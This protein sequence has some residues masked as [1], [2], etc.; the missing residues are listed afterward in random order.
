[1]LHTPRI[2]VA[3]I[4]AMAISQPFAAMAQTTAPSSQPA[5]LGS[6][7]PAPTPAPATPTPA[8]LPAVAQ[9]VS[10][11]MPAATT[12]KPAPLAGAT[13]A[14]ATAPATPTPSPATAPA[15]PVAK[16]PTTAP[17]SAPA[18]AKVKRDYVFQFEGTP[19]VD[20][21]KRFA[22]SVDRPL[23]GDLN[24][25]GTLTFFDSEPYS[26]EEALDTLNILLGMRGFVLA[27]QG[28]YLRLVPIAQVPQMNLK[29]F[30]GLDKVDGVRPSAIITVVLPLK[31]LEPDTAAKSVLRM[32]SSF[33]AISP[34]PRGKGLIITDQLSTIQ[35]IRALLEQMDTD[36]MSNQTI[37]TVVLTK[38][39]ARAVAAILT[40][41]FGS[42]GKAQREGA[43]PE[44]FV[45][46]YDERINM[47]LLMGSEPK[48][49]Q[50]ETTAKNLDTGDGPASGGEVR[51][52]ELKYAKAT[53]LAN[54]LRQAMPSF[55]FQSQSQNENTRTTVYASVVSISAEPSTNRLIISAPVDK[56]DALE[57]L[58]QKLDTAAPVAGSVSKVYR[59]KMADAATLSQV[60]QNAMS[61]R[62]S[63]SEA[64]I[65]YDSRTNSLIV[66]G[67]SSEVEAAG[68]LIQELDTALPGDARD[69]QVVQLQG[70]DARH[71]ASSLTN[72]FSQ[73]GGRKGSL[74]VEVDSESNSL[75]IAAAPG[76]WPIIQEL[77][78]KLDANL[79]T[80]PTGP[81][82]PQP[83]VR[84]LPIRF[85]KVQDIATMVRSFYYGRPTAVNL[86]AY[87]TA[88]T[89]L[90]SASPEDQQGIAEL[91]KSIDVAA[92]DKLQPV[93]VIRIQSGDASRLVETLRGLIPQGRGSDV[94]IQAD[95]V[96]NSVLL[97][98]PQAQR[99]VLQEMIAKLDTETQKHVR[100]MRTVQLANANPQSLAGTVSMLYGA[101]AHNVRGQTPAIIMPGLTDKTLLIDAP[102]EEMEQIV[103]LA[104]SL[105][106][107]AATKDESEPLQII[108]IQASDASRLVDLMKAAIPRGQEQGIF[109]QADP[110]SNSVLLRAPQAKGK[111]VQDMIAKLDVETQKQV[112][113]MRM[114]AL[115]HVSASSL[116]P[117]LQF[118]YGRPSGRRGEELP[119]IAP[120]P[121]DKSLVI[122]APSA[123]IEQIAKT[124]GQ[125]D[126]DPSTLADT[127]PL[128]VIRIQ[129]GDATRL[130]GLLQG[131]I[132]RGM[133]SQVYL[134]AEPQSN[135]VLLRAPENQ[136]KML[137]DM[138]AK[139][140]VATQK[141]VRITRTIRLQFVAGSTMAPML[142]TFYATRFRGGK[143]ETPPIILPGS[144]NRCIVVDASTEGVETITRLAMELDKSADDKVP[145]VQI[146]HIQSNDA[147]KLAETVRAMLPPGPAGQ[148]FLQAD[149]LSN[150]VLLRA[151][152]SQRADLEKLIAR[153]DTETQGQVRQTKM[154]RLSYTS[155]SGLAATLNQLYNSAVARRNMTAAT[156]II[157]TPAW[158]DKTLVVDAPSNKIEQIS[159]MAASLDAPD[160]AA[161]QQ[162]RIYK[163]AQG[164]AYEVAAMLTRV[165]TVPPGQSK[166]PAPRFDYESSGNQLLVSASEAQF[167]RIDKL[168]KELQTNTE[169]AIQTKVFQLKYAVS[170][171]ISGV[172]ESM[173]QASS[174]TSRRR[175]ATPGAVE[176][177]RVAALPS[178]RAVIVQGSPEKLALA[179]QLIASFDVEDHASSNTIQI[180]ELANAQAT[181]LAA[182]V[183]QALLETDPAKKNKIAVTPEMN[184]NSILV[185]GEESQLPR[186]IE[187][188]KKLD[189]GGADS[190]L[191]VKVYPLANGEAVELARTVEKLFG[192]MMRQRARGKRQ[193][194]ATPFSIAADERTNSLV[195]STSPSN[196]K[197]LENLI[198]SMDKTPERNIRQMQYFYLENAQASQLAAKL[199]A[200]YADRRGVDKP[201][202]EGDDSSAALTVIAKEAD[203][204]VVEDAI[205]KLDSAA[206]ENN[207]Q[208]HVIPLS[209]VRAEKMAQVIKRVYGQMSA[210]EV[211]VSDQ[212]LGARPELLLP[213]PA[214]NTSEGVTTA[215]AVTKA[216]AT[217]PGTPAQVARTPNS[218]PTTGPSK[219]DP[220]TRQP[221]TIAVDKSSNALIISANRKQMAEIESLITQLTSTEGNAETEFRTFKI[222]HADP[223]AAAKTLDDLYNAAYHKGQQEAENRRRAT[224]PGMQMPAVPAGPPPEIVAVPDARTQ[225]IIVRA[226]PLDFEV[227][228]EILKELDKDASIVSEVRVFSLKNTDAGEVARNLTDLFALA[229]AGGVESQQSSAGGND[230]RVGYIRQMVELRKA[231]TSGGAASTAKGGQSSV[232][233]SANRQSNSVVVA[234]PSE[235]ME[236]ITRIIQELDQS[237]AVT[238]TPVVRLYPIAG[239]DV[240]AIADSLKEVF[241]SDRVRSRTMMP[242]PPVIITADE[243]RKV[244]IVSAASEKHE[245]IA[246]VLNDL[247]TAKGAEESVT[248]VYTVDFAD[249]SGIAQGLLDTMDAKGT[250]AGKGRLAGVVRISSDRSSNSI[251]VRA[252]PSE[253]ERLAKLITEMDKGPLEQYPV[254]TIALANADAANLAAILNRVFGQIQAKKGTRQSLVI[255]ADANSRTLMVRAD[256]Q[257][258]QKIRQLATQVDSTSPTGKAL[259]TVIALKNADAASVAA[260]LSQAFI[261]QRATRANPDDQVVVVPEPLSNSLVVTA[262]EANL[263]RVQSLLVKLDLESTG[264]QRNEFLLLKNAKAIDLAAVLGKIA[265]S[266][267][268]AKG[269]KSQ[270]VAISADDGSNALVMAGPGLE[271]DRLMKMAA[272]LDKASSSSATGVYILPIKTGQATEVAAMIRDLYTQQ[273]QAARLSKKSID[274]MAVAADDR[275]N[276][277][278]LATSKEMFDQVSTFVNQIEGMKPTRGQMRVIQ[279]PN[280]EPAEVEKA[281]QQIYGPQGKANPYRPNG[282]AGTGKVQVTVLPQQRSILVN[283]SEE[284]YQAIAQLAATLDAAAAG[285]KKNVRILAVKNASPTNVASSL[286]VLFQ[287][288]ARPNMPED[289]VTVTALPGTRAV[290]VAASEEK[291]KDAAGLIES[292]D[293]AD[294]SPKLEFRIYPLINADP[295]KILPMV[296]QLLAQVQRNK[297]ELN[298]TAE[299]DERTRSIVITAGA[300]DFDQIEKVIKTLDQAPAYEKAEIAIIPLR[301]ADATTLAQVLT[302]MLRPSAQGQV[303]PQAKALQEQVRLLRVHS[304]GKE[305]VPEL[306]LNRPI[307]ISADP[308][309]T[310]SNSLIVSSTAEN[311]KAMEAIVEMLDVMPV[312]DGVV[313]RLLHLEHA[314]AA[315]AATVL[316]QVFDQGARLAGK[317][318]S[319]AAGKAQPDT[320]AGKAL[321]NPLNVSVDNRTNTLVVAGV[322]ETVALAELVIKDLDRENGKFNTEVR[323]FKLEHADAT[324]LVDVLRAVFAETGAVPGVEGLTTQVTRLKVVLEK[325]SPT[326][327]PA[328]ADEGNATAV[329]KVRP[330]LTVQADSA[331]NILVVAARADVMPLIADVIRTMDIPGAGSLNT[332]RLY[333]LNNADASRLQQV[334]GSLYAGPNARLIRDEDKPT[335]TVDTR[336]NALVVSASQKTFKLIEDLLTRLDTKVPVDLRDIRL[337]TLQNTDSAQLA[338]TLQKM[339]DARVQ[340]LSA[341][342]AKDAEALKMM[343][344]ADARSNS[345]I[346]GGSAEGFEMVKG[347]AGQLDG[348]APALGGSIQLL[349]LKYGNAGN[350]AATL[351]NLFTKRYQ[352]ARTPDVQKQRPVILS[353]L[354]TNCLLVA[355]TADDSKILAGLLEKL[356]V[357]LT[358]PTVGIH[359]VPLKY[360][361]VGTVGTTIRTIFAARLKSMTPPGQ[362]I[363]PQDQVD[364]GVEPLSNSLI[365]SCS[366][367]N[368]KQIEELLAK[369]DVLP[370]MEGGVVRLFGLEFADAPTTATLLQSLVTQGLYKP[371]VSAAANNP[372]LVAREKISIISDVRTNTLIVSASK[373]NFAVIEEILKRLD[374]STSALLGDIRIYPIKHA[375]VTKLGPMLQQFFNAKR[376]SELTVNDKIH[377]VPVVVVVDPRTSTLL[378]AGGKENF[379]AVEDMIKQLDGD[380]VAGVNDFRI[381]PMKKATATALQPTLTQLFAQ[382][383]TKGTTKD[384]V[385]VIADARSNSLVVGATPDD[386]KLA[387]SL[388]ARLDVEAQ[389]GNTLKVFPLNKADAT[390]VSKTLLE[391][392]RSEGTT[393]GTTGVPTV[394]ISVDERINAILVSAGEN[395][396]KRVEDLVRQLDRDSVTRVAEIRVFGLKNADSA[397]LASILMDTLTN[398]PKPMTVVS[399]SRQTLL[400]FVTRSKE[401][402]D[403]IAS[404]LQEGVLITP[405]KRTNS[406]VVSAPLENMPLLDSL[407]KALDNVSPLAMEIKVFALVNADARQTATILNDL[408]K[409]Q[410]TASK[411]TTQVNYQLASKSTSQPTANDPNS[412]P[413]N[414]SAAELSI[415]V[416]PRTNS[417]L[418]AGTKYY[419]ELA[420]NVIQ[421]LDSQVAQE[422]KTQVYRLRNSQAGD[423]QLALRGFLDQE[424]QRL[425]QTLGNAG[426]GAAERMLEHEVA[427]VAEKSSNTLLLSAS[428]KYF[429]EVQSMIKELDQAPPQVLI[430]VLL[431][432]VSLDDKVDIG[433]EWNL[434]KTFDGGENVLVQ[435]TNFGLRGNTLGSYSLSLTGGDLSLFLRALQSQGRLEVLSRPQILATDNQVAKINVG[436]RVPIVTD[437]RITESG[438]Q[439][440]TVQY[441]D[442]GIILNVTPRINFEGMV[443]MDVAP[444]I[445]SLSSSTV[446]ISTGVNVPIINSRKAETTVTVQ[447]GH[448]II[449]GGLITT[450]DDKRDEKVPCLGDIPLLGWLFK[451]QTAVKTRTELLI[452]L[453]PH[454]I[455]SPSDGDNITHDQIDRL[456][457]LRGIKDS[458][459]DQI[460][461]EL[462]GNG[463]GK[464]L[465]SAIIPST[466]QP[467]GGGAMLQSAQPFSLEKMNGPAATSQPTLE[468]FNRPAVSVPV[469]PAQE[470]NKP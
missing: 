66:H 55:R 429:E 131:L 257:T 340:R 153:L 466:T 232:S 99:T 21:V 12:A 186:V 418:V 133:E 118:L 93:E 400:Q 309:S 361:D 367:E 356:D 192:D 281:V 333:P 365:L 431:A 31:Y 440:S 295:T 132:P 124:A 371:G 359:V 136:Q 357:Q 32:V 302:E 321:T 322:D 5:P 204:A 151:P 144:D 313:V 318:G 254:Q 320:M 306:D 40:N 346:V 448:T 4:L 120:A 350:V 211:S 332:V 298:V 189:A 46:T 280:A 175:S 97:R 362:T 420:S 112:R 467:A 167:E 327:A 80:A 234:A 459:S 29:I 245:L 27:E 178:V 284:D 85:G 3:L 56:M 358:N 287:S 188:I 146:I 117:T 61:R 369:V 334:I 157:L 165:T 217:Q 214:I 252:V 179:E 347:L 196:F 364:V 458:G 314:D 73:Q 265:V 451:K 126:V 263:K 460:K 415:T 251:I 238:S 43:T 397:D 64:S 228:T 209:Q 76:D 169:L 154:I 465:K 304:T 269:V 111:M 10:A 166:E 335:L 49:T 261:L 368:L 53:D 312:S 135:S 402:K 236:T 381:F 249:A 401:G 182:S 464:L 207:Y 450:S 337:V 338:A 218:Q 130:V 406:L 370:T 275:A 272:E 262:N 11:T 432:E 444:E 168:I 342:G 150:T 68:M 107:Q 461:K 58:I 128:Q 90:V 260:S 25:E 45:A 385:T 98:A 286:N 6:A 452:V 276:A 311:L 108:R 291:M 463:S 303:T 18:L 253:Q 289:R 94:F 96:T 297:P 430:Q 277:V 14:P 410:A 69:I 213:S 103:Q 396:L 446:Q 19:Y 7:T 389:P 416:D 138:I 129:T 191:Q 184:S 352:A 407:I 414:A 301:K 279:V 161:G 375:D 377:I 390:Q 62:G 288:T 233:V 174:A 270:Q 221:V 89:L 223:V 462:F 256:E 177:V 81:K 13:P 399:P 294:I 264:G 336:T 408:F 147:L 92:E 38:A 215:P 203:L 229:A 34:M 181:T 398:K 139:L 37:R 244:L 106:A 425:L 212:P 323:L 91:V 237:A 341:L 172:L 354:R 82:T 30:A 424:R 137:Q 202:I 422:R 392:Y 26:T 447:D 101:R 160:M 427:V 70:G 170:Y 250:S 230:R 17:A 317:P 310:G 152:E 243:V 395:D 115:K 48:L 59:L 307:K 22:Q 216:P 35:R 206:A 443:K 95:P 324:K 197:V 199:N 351:D 121:G 388:V 78:R 171:E 201:M 273:L 386:M 145:P 125:M 445:S 363:S 343:I 376:Q 141:D 148:I 8:M 231:G 57:K 83:S 285:K 47:V 455:R 283:A 39:S 193:V 149:P 413:A 116:S 315:S 28:R 163:L 123:T 54:A 71:I 355:A 308:A 222:E 348:A 185:R 235:A 438:S 194:E 437:S 63:G 419:L 122:D 67:S 242:E 366:K 104:T 239:S 198:E 442:V 134:Q 278:V 384:P 24:V 200:M 380:Q 159:Q 330:A 411:N 373:E 16:A 156:E 405:D 258:F 434:K 42:A 428:P 109:L 319:G 331:S 387:E 255:E 328:G 393:G 195:V 190:S 316:R 176:Q 33:G 220:P 391:L 44:N 290:V 75:M 468:Q 412:G 113:Q 114:I 292:L 248:R 60:V 349:P 339:M 449:I 282:A 219:Y 470:T 266:S 345:L 162:V 417:L 210:N 9:V 65:S 423:I 119:V 158:G 36:T 453:T 105:D 226:K 20:V 140:D 435:G 77:L 88:N 23:I 1:M 187:M 155:A 52:F 329:A 439:I 271:I 300:A 382:R 173:L 296:R 74:R 86:V 372:S 383:V 225:Q 454:V 469:P 267:S 409:L 426:V 344:V 110:M 224:P 259:P 100:Q 436:Q 247:S 457:L 241:V 433:M 421:E 353:D 15:T 293:K 274:P 143:T 325:T 164:A 374:R 379:A 360:N 180:V 246:K 227:I 240:R 102:G 403:L 456:N 208:V 2:L 72:L 326:T 205:E 394:G 299:A 87:D 404:A 127:P 142:Q 268:G 41:L 305:Q 441:E 50:A 183:N 51:V 79:A 84:L 378:V